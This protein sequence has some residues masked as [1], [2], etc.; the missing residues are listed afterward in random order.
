MVIVIKII[1]DAYFL[2]SPTEGIPFF[3]KD[4]YILLYL[5]GLSV[6]SSLLS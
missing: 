5:T 1:H 3:I 2:E 6:L 4:G